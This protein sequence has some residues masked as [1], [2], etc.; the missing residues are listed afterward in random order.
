MRTLAYGLHR[1]TM[2]QLTQSDLEGVLGFLRGCEEY[3]ELDSLRVGMLRELGRLIP[4]DSACLMEGDPG[5][6]L[7][8][9]MEPEEIP[10]ADNSAWRDWSHQHPTI[11]WYRDHPAEPGRALH[12]ADFVSRRDWHALELY[13][14]FFERYE[15][16]DQLTISW[17]GAQDEPVGIP[18]NRGRRSF[19]ARE[20]ELLDVLRPHIVQLY[21]QANE[22][23]RARRAIAAL[24]QAAREGGRAVV[25]LGRDESADFATGPALDWMREYFPP[26]GDPADHLPGPL[27]DWVSAARQRLNGNGNGRLPAPAAPLVLER[28]DGRLRISFVAAGAPGEQDALLLE[29][30]RDGLPA[31]RMRALGLTERESAVMRCADRG[32]TTVQIALELGNSPRT[33]Q[34]HLE[35]I[36]QKLEVPTR[37]AALA[38]IRQDA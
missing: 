22:R 28:G 29:E 14:A 16:E 6:G 33:V 20:R 17:R 25:L 32:L 7:Y 12:L 26:N 11:A 19:T 36:Y 35:R 10:P 38:K 15:I 37:T 8:W 9:T 23:A 21:R 13:Q 27:A 24:D 4:Y 34:K 2:A 5:R 18:V 3:Q 31:D 30:R 1:G